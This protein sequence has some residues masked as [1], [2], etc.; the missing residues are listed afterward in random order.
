MNK[1]PVIAGVILVILISAGYFFIPPERL[2]LQPV[3]AVVA[4]AATSSPS[5]PAS[6]APA[7]PYATYN[8]PSRP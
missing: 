5:Q 7:D 4:P 2:G 8:A 1:W 3:P 6:S